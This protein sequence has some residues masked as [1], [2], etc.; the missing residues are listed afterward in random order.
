M[1]QVPGHFE[2][3][4]IRYID[5]LIRQFFIKDPRLIRLL[6]IL[7]ALELMAQER[8]YSGNPDFRMVFRKKPAQ[9]HGGPGGP[10]G[11]DNVGHLAFCLRPDLRP[12]GPVMYLPVCFAVELV[13]QE[14]AVRMFS[15]HDIGLLNGPVGTPL[16][17]GEH[18]FHTIGFHDLAPLNTG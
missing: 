7:E 3:F 2:G 11:G 14:V 9:P 18:N 16:G 1:G 13:G 17:R 5:N 15:G 4:V 12:G 8:F 10:Q 6:H